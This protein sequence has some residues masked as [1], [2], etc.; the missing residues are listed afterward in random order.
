MIGLLSRMNAHVAL[1]RLQVAEV[2]A[3][4]LAGVR[5]LPGV[6]EHVGAQ[7]GHLV[8]AGA[9]PNNKS[10]QRA[11][12]GWTGRVAWVCN[13]SHLNESGAARLTLVGLFPR[14]D[15]GV[16]LE[17]GRSVELGAADVAVVGFRTWSRKA[18]V[19]ILACDSVGANKGGESIRPPGPH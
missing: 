2:R 18:T 11:R 19:S 12:R 13:C 1:E 3:A 9:M 4:D 5:L 14:V 6:D 10:V 15:A 7:V 17:V 8:A 16:R